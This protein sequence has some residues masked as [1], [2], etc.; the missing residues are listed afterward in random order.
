MRLTLL[1][2]RRL[3]AARRT[4][5]RRDDATHDVEVD[6]EQRLERAV[7]EVRDRVCGSRP[8]QGPLADGL[9]DRRP[10]SLAHHGFRLTS[11][12]SLLRLGAQP[13]LPSM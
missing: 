12:I 13:N 1:Q 11:F 7:P 2:Q 10:G 4:D 5:E 9:C 8:A 3:S 6:I